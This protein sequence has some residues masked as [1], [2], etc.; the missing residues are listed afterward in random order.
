M[1]GVLEIRATALDL[2]KTRGEMRVIDGV[3]GRVRAYECGSL[4]FLYRTPFQ[5][6]HVVSE[7]MRIK[8]ALLEQA[9]GRKM[10]RNLLDFP[11]WTHPI[12]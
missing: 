5:Q 7:E 6:L 4:S 9:V 8:V 3:P 11:L 12:S 1:E 2:L 10:S